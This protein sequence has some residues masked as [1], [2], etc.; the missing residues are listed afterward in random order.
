MKKVI[1]TILALL[2]LASCSENS[3]IDDSLSHASPPASSSVDAPTSDSHPSSANLSKSS[4][5]EI[6]VEYDDV[7]C[8]YREILDMD[9]EQGMLLRPCD[10]GKDVNENII[11]GRQAGWGICY[12]LYDIDDDGIRELI[13]GNSMETGDITQYDIFTSRDGVAMNVF[14]DNYKDVYIGDPHFGFRFFFTIQQNGIIAVSSYTGTGFFT[15]EFYR[16]S[17]TGHCTL[18]EGVFIDHNFLATKGM[19]I[20]THFTSIADVGDNSNPKITKAEYDAIIDKYVCISMDVNGVALDWAQLQ[21]SNHE[22]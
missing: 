17:P 8:Q 20:Y 10:L 7:L 18:I 14:A 12:A 11:M 15:S 6:P 9:D 21:S 16:I 5:M 19:T 3:I 2:T 1:W 4:V 13:V 22:P